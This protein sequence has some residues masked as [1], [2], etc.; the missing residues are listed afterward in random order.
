MI[1]C[2]LI[3]NTKMF[4]DLFV[5]IILCLQY[6]VFRAFLFMGVCI[7]FVVISSKLILCFFKRNILT[8]R[9]KKNTNSHFSMCQYQ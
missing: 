6:L 2:I 8:F 5:Y 1:V 7:Y 3:E 9:F 4:E